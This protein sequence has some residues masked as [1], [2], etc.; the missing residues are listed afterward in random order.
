MGAMQ[1]ESTP[2]MNVGSSPAAVILVYALADLVWFSGIH[3]SSVTSV[4]IPVIIAAV[5]PLYLPSSRSPI[6]KR[7]RGSRP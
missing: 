2:I 5:A 6:S 4:F 1:V 3:P 7:T